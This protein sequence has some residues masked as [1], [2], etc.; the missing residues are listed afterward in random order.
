MLILKSEIETADFD[1]LL[2]KLEKVKM[3]EVLRN[4]LTNLKESGIP[5]STNIVHRRKFSKTQNI[6]DFL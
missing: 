4:M 6:F 2:S 3:P 5:K 1:K